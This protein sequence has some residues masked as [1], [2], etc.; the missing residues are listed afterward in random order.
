M[1]KKGLFRWWLLAIIVIVLDQ[2]SK[3]AIVARLTYG[4]VIP[5][6]AHFNLVLAHNPGAAFSFLSDQ[7]GWQRHF[8]TVLAIVVSCVIAVILRKHHAETRFAAAMSLIMG[9]AIGNVVDRISYGYVI[10]F[11]DVYWNNSHW[12]AFNIA[13]SAICIGA[14]LMLLDSFIKPK[15]A[16]VTP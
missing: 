5:V 10:D 1:L 8:F 4:Q 7:S 6:F 3:L 2:A 11:L 12:P 13:D 15:P 9:G 16:S 14:G